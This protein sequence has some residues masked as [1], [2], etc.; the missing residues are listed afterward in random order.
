MTAYRP[1]LVTTALF[2]LTVLLHRDAWLYIVE[3]A[4]R[5]DRFDLCVSAL[6]LT[7]YFVYRRQARLR[8]GMPNPM[9]VGLVLWKVVGDLV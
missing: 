4:Q 1:A 6:L 8:L 7:G 3:S 5:V 9:G 2:L